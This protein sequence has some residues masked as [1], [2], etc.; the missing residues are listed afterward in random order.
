MEVVSLT[1]LASAGRRARAETAALIAQV[2]AEAT[3][4]VLPLKPPIGHT[5][6]AARR[7]SGTR[8]AHRTLTS[9][10]NGSARRTPA[11]HWHREA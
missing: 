7:P 6:G 11:E 9:G 5:A 1:A 2:T 4:P 3:R 8:R 10:T